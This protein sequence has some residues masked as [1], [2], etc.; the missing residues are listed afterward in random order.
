MRTGQRKLSV[1]LFYISSSSFIKKA[2][3]ASEG[4]ENEPRGERETF[5]TRGPS[6]TQ[7]RLNC[8]IKKRRI[9]V[10]SHLSI[11]SDLYSFSNTEQA[12]K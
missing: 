1:L 2:N 12:R 6:G 3:D 10:L 11:V 4:I 5:V 7:E 9:N 8:E